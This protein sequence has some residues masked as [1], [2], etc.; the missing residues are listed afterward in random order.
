MEEKDLTYYL[1][2]LRRI[3]ELDKEALETLIA[4]YPYFQNLH[5]LHAKQQF[6]SEGAFSEAD[7]IYATQRSHF[8]R[9]VEEQSW[10]TF[11]LEKE[12]PVQ[13]QRYA[14]KVPLMTG[15]KDYTI[16][17][18]PEEELTSRPDEAVEANEGVTDN[19]LEDYPYGAINS[20]RVTMAEPEQV[21]PDSVGEIIP[22]KS[23]PAIPE[24]EINPVKRPSQ[25]SEE[26]IPAIIRTMQA[27]G[28]TSSPEADVPL[29]E[30]SSE[31][32]HQAESDK[33]SKSEREARP[34]QR[35]IPVVPNGYGVTPFTKWLHDLRRPFE[36]NTPSNLSS[37]EEEDRIDLDI[38]LTAHLPANLAGQA[39]SPES[40]KYPDSGSTQP[41]VE[42]TPGDQK[43]EEATDLRN[44][45][46]AL[47][48]SSNEIKDHIGSETLAKLLY[49]QGFRDL[50]I[51]MYERLALNNPEKSSYFADQIRIIRENQ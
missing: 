6:L 23:S 37:S 2:D 4:K 49:Q 17:V 46:L 13:P 29:P 41:P 25:E 5:L 33:P 3:E 20:D 12:I 31:P 32:A 14:T 16:P 1:T 44:E 19:T 27:T 9:Q 26:L 51:Q 28:G 15:E 35:S 36:E 48:R 30:I 11:D 39:T 24:A 8:F 40:K 22:E 45:Y 21:S 34:S 42:P 10:D 7:V 47:A 38:P 50:A 43:N 18:D